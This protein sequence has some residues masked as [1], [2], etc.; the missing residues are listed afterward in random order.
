[1]NARTRVRSAQPRR[2]RGAC[3]FATGVALS[4]ALARELPAEHAPLAALQG[5]PAS[6]PTSGP[7]SA[8]AGASA[9]ATVQEQRGQLD[10]RGQLALDAGLAWLARTLEGSVDGSLPRGEAREWAPVG[11]TSLA[12]LAWMAGGSTPERGLHGAP[13]ARAIDYLIAQCELS[14]SAPTRGYIGARGDPLSRMHGHGYATLVL[15]EAWCMSPRSARG[16]RIEVAL[17]AA[18]DLIERTQGAEGG[19]HYEP[20]LV[21]QHEG[22]ITVCLVQALRAAHGAGMRVSN[23]TIARAEGYV[24]ASQA[25]DGRFRYMLGSDRTSVALTAA[26]I[27]TL[28]MAGT[29]EGARIQSGVDAIWRGLLARP[30]SGEALSEEQVLCSFYERLHLAQ[31][32][33]QLDDLT[34]FE[35]WAGPERA[36]VIAAQRPSGA[37]HDPR[38]G[39]AYATAMNSLFL[40]LTSGYLPIFAR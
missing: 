7:T 11:V 34:H 35:R 8:P 24:L 37:W 4:L 13:L 33:W 29:Y 27:A 2:A 14:P 21:A 36:R 10:E 18:I 9:R 20:Q 1:M 25:P 32:F 15:A 3:G 12:A 19:W 22:S 39:D 23:E 26:A 28:N 5:P 31:V 38:Y 30:S 16:A 17:R 6:A 40:A